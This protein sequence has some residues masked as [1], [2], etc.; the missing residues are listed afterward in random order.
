VGPSNA[1]HV[2]SRRTLLVTV[3]LVLGAILVGVAVEQ[4]S[5]GPAAAASEPTVASDSIPL[6][7][8]GDDASALW[9]YTSRSRSVEGRTLAINVVVHGKNDR[10][11]RALTR[12]TDADWDRTTDDNARDADAEPVE[13][14]EIDESGVEWRPARGAARYT[15]V[16]GPEATAGEWVRESYQLHDGDYL[17]SRYHV[18]AYAAPDGEWTAL[19]AHEESFDWFRLR[20]TVTGAASAQTFVETDLRDERFVAE[21][22]RTWTGDRWLSEVELASAVAVLALGVP[23]RELLVRA[24]DRDAPL[25]EIDPAAVALFGA[26]LGLFL[27]VRFGGVGFEQAFPDLSP[28]VVAGLLYPLLALGLPFVAA[29]LARWTEPLA[30]FVAAAAGLGTAFVVDYAYLGISTLPV[31]VALHR[32]AVVVV[33]GMVAVGAARRADGKHDGWLVA[34]A[35]GWLVVLA[36]PL[37]GLL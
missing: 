7:E 19:Q 12:R 33:L 17:G 20:H 22:G 6:F 29:A 3:G 2:P 8:S 9:P 25:D 26:T 28:K 11:H 36:L 18:R 23:W 30:G 27:A 32:V 13:A 14:I 5:P 10:V 35:V 1:E 21:L 37:F 24:R 4:V 34:G 31:S 15:Y 16:V